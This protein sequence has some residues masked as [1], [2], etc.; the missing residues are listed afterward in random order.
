MYEWPSYWVCCFGFFCR[1]QFLMCCV[2]RARERERGCRQNPFRCMPLLYVFRSGQTFVLCCFVCTHPL[3]VSKWNVLAKVQQEYYWFCCYFLITFLMNF[4]HFAK[5]K[6]LTVP[7][8]PA[9][10]NKLFINDNPLLLLLKNSLASSQHSIFPSVLSC[11]HLFLISCI[12]PIPLRLL[13]DILHRQRQFLAD[14]KVNTL[15]EPSQVSLSCIWH[16]SPS[17]TSS[18]LSVSQS[19]LSHS[20]YS[21]LPL[22]RLLKATY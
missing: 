18:A 6:Y 4:M 3:S 2:K 19:V 5:L 7:Y 13:L 15:S 8:Q 14:Q 22:P 1:V 21:S 20:L 12:L 11:C 9:S 17:H 10:A 16:L